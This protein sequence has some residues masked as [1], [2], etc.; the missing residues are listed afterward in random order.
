MSWGHRGCMRA[1]RFASELPV[2]TGGFTLFLSCRRWCCRRSP[3]AP[4]SLRP[5]PPFPLPP[6]SRPAPL[7]RIRRQRRRRRT[8]RLRLR[9]SRLMH[10]RPHRLSP[11]P[12]QP[13]QLRHR[14]KARRSIRSLTHMSVSSTCSAINRSPTRQ[15]LRHRLRRRIPQGS[16]RPSLQLR[17][18]A[19]MPC[20]LPR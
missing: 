17:L 2:R 18:P 1:Q 5:L 8:L 12:R 3:A 20:N 7:T 14:S 11:R 9:R 6:P 16:R 19:V 4:R 13:H 10:L 15:R